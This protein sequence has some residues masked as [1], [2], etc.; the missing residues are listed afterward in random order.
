M[1]NQ[2]SGDEHAIAK[3]PTPSS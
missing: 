1:R 3:V 2:L